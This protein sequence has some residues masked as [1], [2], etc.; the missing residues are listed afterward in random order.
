M[1]S[2]TKVGAV[3]LHKI[4]AGVLALHVFQEVHGSLAAT[5]DG[6][7]AGIAVQ[8]NIVCKIKV[9]FSRH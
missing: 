9:F 3:Q 2:D 7:R 6:P 4:H 1:R 5:L 8:S